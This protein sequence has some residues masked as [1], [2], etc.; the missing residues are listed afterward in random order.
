MRKR[1]AVVGLVTV[2]TLLAV[3]GVTYASGRI[4]RVSGQGASQSGALTGAPSPQALAEATR[5]LETIQYSFREVAKKVLPVVVEIDVTEVVKQQT[6]M[7]SP[8]DWF[9]NQPPGGGRGGERQFRRSGLG[10]GILVKKGGGTY[11]VLTNNHVVDSATNISVK[12]SDQRVFKAKVVGTDPRKD[13]AVVSFDSRDSVPVADLGDSND[14]QV[15]DIVLAVGNPLG[16]EN[17]ITMGIVSALGRRGPSGQVAQNTDYIQTDAA[18]NQGNSGGALVNVKGEVVGINTWIAAPT[19]GNVG[20]G[21]AIPVNNAKK[22]IDDFI[23]KGKVE[24]G[25]LGVMPDDIQAAD[26]NNDSYPGVARDLSVAG[27]KG[28]LVINVY[29]NSPADKSGMLP[30]DYITRVNGQ[31][32]PDRDHLIQAV[33]DLPAG[34]S[35]DFEIIRYGEKVR[36]PIRL[37][38]R[39][40]DTSEVTSYKYLWPGVTVVRINDQI[41]Q[42]A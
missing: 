26:P 25:W 36:L 15:G 34:R 14:I 30:G 23:S 1:L 29:R 40:D 9:F 2:V 10:S 27:V 17:T 3:S 6:P 39:P 41:R 38:V 12:L 20:L 19:G 24:Y 5:N 33:G 18:I 42:D 28:T 35:Y 4:E 32:I 22:A 21:F 31:D 8:F 13:L 37:G 7:Q 11:Y 16:F